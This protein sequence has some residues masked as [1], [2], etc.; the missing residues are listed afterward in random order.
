V[1][2]FALHAHA[3]PAKID[4]ELSFPT[5]FNDVLDISFDALL[6]DRR[7]PFFF[8]LERL[9]RVPFPSREK[10]FLAIFLGAQRG[11]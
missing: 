1:R 8:L 7:I 3:P 11:A 10:G 9:S 2:S 6:F 4:A 5:V